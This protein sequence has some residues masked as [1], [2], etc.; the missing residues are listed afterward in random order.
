MEDKVEII[1]FTD[2]VC[3][4]CWGSEPLLRKLEMRYPG[5]VKL[6]FIMGGLVRDIRDFHDGA[7]GIGG[8]PAASNAQIAAHW[9]EASARH[10]MPV[11]TEGFALFT[12]EQPSTYPQNIAYKAA[13]LQG[14]ALADKFLRRMREAS[15]AEARQ[16]NKKEVLIELASEAGLDVGR[17][18][19]SV[20]DGSALAA[21][22]KDLELTRRYGV[23]GFPTFLVRYGSQEILLRGHQGYDSFKAVIGQ[24][25][26]GSI[27]E[28]VPA[29][30]DEAVLAFI[31][32]C[33]KVA[34]VELRE[35]FGFTA[36]E[37]K[38]ALGRL[39]AKRAILSRP[40]GN[41]VFITAAKSPLACD[42]GSGVCN[43]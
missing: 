34:P 7:H 14:P 30:T 41:G 37:V 31:E 43:L 23:S 18:L 32:R 19:A 8:D 9:L 1:E 27:R 2:P 4:W 38:A 39:A 35:A 20:D 26:G 3:T 29:R 12:K 16:T 33:G 22:E 5:R 6:R 24:L 40:A 11:K 42:A 25:T 28:T 15:A 17:F 10:G 13:Q 36:E 21:F